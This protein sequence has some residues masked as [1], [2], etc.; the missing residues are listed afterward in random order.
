[1]RERVVAM[2]ANV[3]DE[4]AEG[5]ALGL[6]I[7]VP[8]PMPKALEEPLKPEVKAS[9]ALSLFARPGDGSISTRRVAIL[10]ADG[11]DGACLAQIHA[12][13]T[14]A[15]SGAALRRRASRPSSDGGRTPHRG[16]S[17]YGSDA[18]RAF[19]CARLA[20]RPAAAEALGNL[21]HALEFI[22][23]QYRHCKPILV[24]GAGTSLIENA[25]VP[26]TLPSG[27][28]DPGLLLFKEGG[29]KEALSKFTEAIAK[30]RHYAREIDPP[31]V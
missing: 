8:A 30:H 25:G 3:A 21:G 28:P 1:M 17:D 23:D 31:A 4:L 19:R 13:L 16:R 5:V 12:G 26:A 29:A 6:G 20:R 2:L 27:E 11:V 18:R 7:K 24:L 15:R 22:K 9:R 10:V 14:R